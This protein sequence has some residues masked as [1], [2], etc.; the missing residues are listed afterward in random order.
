MVTRCGFGCGEWGGG[1]AGIAARAGRARLA[2]AAAALLCC[3]LAGVPGASHARSAASDPVRHAVDE[4]I[5]AMMRKDQIPG[6]AVGII[7]DGKP[8]VFNYGMAS[9]ETH[10]PVNGNTL[11]ELGSVSKTFT[12]TLTAWAQVN[13]QLSLT[14]PV[15]HYLPTLRGSAFGRV[16][17]L[18]LGT[19][20]PGGLPLQVP[21]EIHD[22]Q[23]LLAYFKAWRPAYAPG[24]RRT[25]TNPGIGTLGWIAAQSMGQD[26]TVLLEQ[27]LFPALGLTNSFIDVPPDRAADYAQGYTK[28][29]KP[30]RLMGGVLGPEAYG[31][32]ASAA[33]MLRFIEANMKLVDVAAPLQR[34]IID[35][36]TGY[37]K[38]GPITQDL[39]WEQYPYPVALNTLLAG[40][41]PAMLSDAMQAT[42][43]DPPL[44]PMNDAW[45]NK[46]GSTNGF[47]SY[48]AF[49]P[50][51]RMG[52]V[53]LANRSFPIADRV[54]AAYRILSALDGAAQ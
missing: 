53:I 43:I 48:V 21:D 36:H 32:K 7:V 19:H 49:V 18:N 16:S 38:S 10:Q 39:I 5:G 23:Q 46:T 54:A 11:F 2:A 41:G 15:D 1:L 37:F 47:G 30:I 52:I 42:A 20:T 25:Y 6:V 27:R 17:L 26:F 51:K 33:D 34:A 44:P 50:A 12:A 28:D 14:D 13:H 45:I 40:N 24:T 35:T 22:N 29:G 3:A 9:L 8:A 4:S 31:V